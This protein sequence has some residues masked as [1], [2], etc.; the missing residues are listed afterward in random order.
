MTLDIPYHRL[1]SQHIA[2]PDFDTPADVV[3]WLGA[4]QGQDFL[5]ALWAIGMRMPHAVEADVER[6]VTDKSIVRLWFMRGTLHFLAAED[7]RWMNDLMSP[8]LRLVSENGLRYLRAEMDAQ[9]VTRALDVVAKSLEGVCL[10]REELAT[11]LEQSGIPADGFRLSFIMQTAQNNSLV[12]HGARRG[13]QFTFALMD[14]WIPPAPKKDRET[15]LVD[16]ARRYFTGHAPATIQDFVAW[17]GLTLTEARAGL[18]GAKVDLD[19]ET[20]NGK[21]Y[22]FAPSTVPKRKPKNADSDV[23]LLS[24]FDEYV[25][26]YQDR[27]MVLDTERQKLW[28][29]KNAIFKSLIVID[30]QVVGFWTRT[31]KKKTVMIEL[32]PFEPLSDAHRQKADE[33]ADR[34]GRFLALEAVTS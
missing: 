1:H 29:G 34:Y 27:T 9:T 30:G 10:T 5:G 31:I 19:Q 21:T 26:G 6:A 13:K 15:A 28:R 25:L 16:F 33:V 17:S 8:R 14:E 23:Y 32:Q 4:M 12:C 7:V 11:A 3:R 20:F 2:K 24:G 22:W 18:E